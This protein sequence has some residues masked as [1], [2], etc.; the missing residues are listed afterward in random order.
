MFVHENKTCLILNE[1]TFLFN[2][3][4]LIPR[5]GTALILQDAVFLHAVGLLSVGIR[6]LYPPHLRFSTFH[7]NTSAP[8]TLDEDGCRRPCV[9]VC[10]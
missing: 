6:T 2:A 3:T 10:V 5:V 7:R 9:W 4:S 1:E 8:L